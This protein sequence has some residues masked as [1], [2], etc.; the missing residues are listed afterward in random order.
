MRIH[1][2]AIRIHNIAI[3]IHNIAIR[4]HKITIKI[5]KHNN[6]NASIIK[7]FRTIQNIQSYIYIYITDI[8][9]GSDLGSAD[10]GWTTRAKNTVT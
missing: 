7:F 5:Y 2:I 3:R 4:I 1:N 6:K 10:G 8:E 9:T